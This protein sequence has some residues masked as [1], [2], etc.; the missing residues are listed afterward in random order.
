MLRSG[1]DHFLLIGSFLSTRFRGG[2]IILPT[3]VLMCAWKM[4]SK[5]HK[6]Y[7]FVYLT[8]VAPLAQEYIYIYIYTHTVFHLYCVVGPIT[9]SVTEL[10]MLYLRP[11]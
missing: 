2:G 8:T 9:L 7:I 11:H 1:V 6:Q 10:C 3:S 4:L 5:Q